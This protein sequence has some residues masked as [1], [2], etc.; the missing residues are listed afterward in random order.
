MATG[1]KFFPV[2]SYCRPTP[3]GTIDPQCALKDN[4]CYTE[5]DYIKKFGTA[6]P[7][8]SALSPTPTSQPEV[9]TVRE[10]LRYISGPISWY[11]FKIGNTK[12]H[13]FG[14][15]HYSK[16]HN[17]Q[18]QG[19]PC[20]KKDTKCTDFPNL[21]Q[22]LFQ[23]SVD[24][25]EY[26]DFYLETPFKIKGEKT[27][28]IDQL[29]MEY[30]ETH[31]PKIKKAI[32]KIGYIESVYL[33]FNPCFQVE[34]VLCPYAPYVRFHYVDLR[35][36][37]Q[38]D[39][40]GQIT[41]N[42]YLYLEKIDAIIQEMNMYFNAI[43]ALGSDN[44]KAKKLKSQITDSVD[45]VNSLVNKILLTGRTLYGES[46]NYNKE[47]FRAMISS[48]DYPS[49]IERI[50][51]HL[52]E[53]INPQSKDYQDFE[54]LKLAM[55]RASTSKEGKFMHRG[56]AQLYALRKDG[57][58]F[59]GTNIADLIVDFVTAEFNSFNMVDIYNIWKRFYN[60]VYLPFTKI[61][62]FEQYE[63]VH[64]KLITF[65]KNYDSETL[66]HLIHVD[67]LVLDVYLLARMFR[68]FNPEHKASETIIT[69]TGAA[70]TDRYVKFF[71]QY[72]DEKPIDFIK[73]PVA[74]ANRCLQ[75]P[76]FSQYF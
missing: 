32:E 40:E 1:C 31:D 34:K 10:G 3:T 70:H 14:D 23:R 71:T 24:K 36:T 9:Q 57:I 19:I 76:K 15:Q 27:D 37:V 20:S 12:F 35:Q 67:S 39:F 43:L 38:A 73:S 16:A 55:I 2:G 41:L 60:D 53:G 64:H 42:N 6:P 26:V 21:L 59:R 61:T 52:L 44:Q 49:D 4:R 8:P 18:S 45:F 28:P 51:N 17:C 58:F 7:P 68:K 33:K 13:F 5:A 29:I 62:F 63:S 22:K 65:V 69:F 56:A 74:E 50:L 75:N 54:K 30:Q 72:L 25:K 46:F 48:T 11:Y 66:A 47:L